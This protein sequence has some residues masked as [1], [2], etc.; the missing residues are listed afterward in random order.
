[1]PRLYM[2]KILMKQTFA[3]ND[4]DGNPMKDVVEKF[5]S[6]LIK[7][8]KVAEIDTMFSRITHRLFS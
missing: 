1:M 2:Y 5:V 4:K 3:I 7:Q 8:L 6:L